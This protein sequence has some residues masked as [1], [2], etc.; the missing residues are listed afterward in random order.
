MVYALTL[1]YWLVPP[2]AILAAGFLARIFI[3]F[4]DCRHDSFFQSKRANQVIGSIAGLLNL[5][6]IANWRWQHAASELQIADLST[7][8]R[9]AKA[10]RGL[11]PFEG[12]P[13]AAT[14]LS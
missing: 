9:A 8:G 1:S 5:T 14:V 4:H 6:H 10:I 13:A 7:P 3:I 12:R 2:L 11:P